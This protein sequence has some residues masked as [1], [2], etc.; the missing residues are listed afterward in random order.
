MPAMQVKFGTY[1]FTA[2]A[3]RL[4]IRTV[5]ELDAKNQP[6]LYTNEIDVTGRL[7][8]E[9]D[10]SLSNQERQLR[11]GLAQRGAD[12]GILKRDGQSSASWWPNAQTVYG[13]IVVRG[14][15]FGGT[16][17]SEYVLYREFSFTVRNQVAI[18]DI[19]N[20]ILE[21]KETVTYDGGEPE[22]KFKR[23]INAKPQKQ[24]VWFLTEYRVTQS[25]R[26]VGYRDYPRPANFLFPGD[27]E[28][29]PRYTRESPDRDGN[30]FTRYPVTWEYSFASASP[31]VGLPTRWIQ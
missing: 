9:G 10:D 5:A 7:Y 19:A 11:V 12:F 20:A 2:G 17:A 30:N 21:F 23:A 22:F 16:T 15:D 27:R 26:A 6:Y 18:A 31:L 28:R 8:G 25:G 13:N 4:G 24:L 3:C 1:S 29:S 14:P